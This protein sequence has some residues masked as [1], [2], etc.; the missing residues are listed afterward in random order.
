MPINEISSDVMN[1]IFTRSSETMSEIPDES[2]PLIVTS[3]PHK[4]LNISERLKAYDANRYMLRRV[5]KEC[6][7]ILAD[8]GRMCVHV[9]NKG[10]N[11]YIPFSSHVIEDLLYI[12]FH[13]R[14]DIIWN[15]GISSGTTTNWGTFGSAQ[16]PILRDIHEYILVFG[17]GNQSRERAATEEEKLSSEVFTELTLSVWNMRPAPTRKIGHPEAVPIELPRRC[18][19]LYS[20]P[21]DVVVDPFIGS[22]TTALAALSSRRRFV[23]YEI[24]EDYSS[25]SQSR[26][27]SYEEYKAKTGA[28]PFEIE[29]HDED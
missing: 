19:L 27:V 2:V 20:Y 26:I 24:N 3:P 9:Q 17:K 10:R 12:G 1:K 15:K 14:G 13:M 5:W 22:G 16:N 29:R 21:N 11:P 23:G 4:D 18:I 28:Y 25:L 8:G 6:H 7:R